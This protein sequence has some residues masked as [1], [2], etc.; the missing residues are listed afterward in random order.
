MAQEQLDAAGACRALGIALES[1]EAWTRAA[2]DVTLADYRGERADAP[3]VLRFLA[4]KATRMLRGRAPAR[5]VV[6]F[7]RGALAQGAVR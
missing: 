1:R 3:K 7:V 4:G 5:E 6:E 2:Q